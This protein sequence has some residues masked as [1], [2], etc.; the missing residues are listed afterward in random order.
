MPEPALLTTVSEARAYTREVRARGL[1]VGLVPTMGALHAGHQSLIERAAS[2]C[3]RVAVSVFVNPIQFDSPADLATYPRT[4]AADTERAAQAGA[5]ALFVPSEREMYPDGKP[6]TLVRVSGLTEVLEG[7]HRPGHFDGVTTVCAKLFEACEPDR[8]YF[9]E[10]DYQ[11][12]RVVSRMVRDLNMAVEIVPCPLIRE[13]D[14]LA[15]SSRNVR[16]SDEER[17]QALSISRGLMAAEA[18]F[19]AGERR[20]DALKALAAEPVASAPLA[21]PDYLELVDAETL[22]TVETV[23]APAVLLTAVRMPSARL[24]DNVIL[25]PTRR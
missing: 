8:A 10:K 4:L 3:D 2:E 6:L 1:R 5:T 23:E 15:L 14:G 22:E 18:A 24:L 19:Q 13:E 11:Q 20:A 17:R 25:D 16:L 7:A 9:G 21:E 12:L